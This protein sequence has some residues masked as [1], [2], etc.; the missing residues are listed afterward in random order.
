FF[1]YDVGDIDGDGL[2]DIV[3]SNYDCTPNSPHAL[4]CVHESKTPFT[5]P[6]TMV[7]FYCYDFYGTAGLPVYITDLDQDERKEIVFF[8]GLITYF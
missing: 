8:L 2:S 1:P 6:D 5:H 3:G 4:I 7:F